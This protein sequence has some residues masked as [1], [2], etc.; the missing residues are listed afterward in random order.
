MILIIKEKVYIQP[1]DIK[2]ILDNY[3]ETNIPE[4]L[5]KIENLNDNKFIELNNLT[6]IQ[7][8]LN[9]K[10]IIKFNDFI[11]MSSSEVDSFVKIEKN[12]LEKY[13]YE[14][15]YDTLPRPLGD[16]KNVQT[17]KTNDLVDLLL[18]CVDYNN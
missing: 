2:Y 18:I 16:S 15:L 13:I 8:V 7:F 6:T 14:N 5:K 4:E 17:T 1:I 11:E 9:D 10:N 3:I 12:K